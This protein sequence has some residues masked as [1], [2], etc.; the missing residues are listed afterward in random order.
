MS[1]KFAGLV[2]PPPPTS[3][4]LACCYPKVFS[5]LKNVHAH[6]IEVILDM[7]ECALDIIVSHEDVLCGK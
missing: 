7:L 3:K 2:P 4:C 1:S 5:Q 6:N